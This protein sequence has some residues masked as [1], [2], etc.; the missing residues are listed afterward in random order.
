MRSFNAG[1]V[2]ALAA[3]AAVFAGAAGTQPDASSLL[4]RGPLDALQ[5]K[6]VKLLAFSEGVVIRGNAHINF[7]GVRIEVDRNPAWPARFYE[8][9]IAE[10]KYEVRPRPAP[11]APAA[12]GAPAGGP[13][14]SEAI[15][16]KVTPA[17][18]VG[19]RTWFDGKAEQI[20]DEACIAGEFG[21]IRVDG[22]KEW[23]QGVR[24]AFVHVEGEL[25][26]GPTEARAAF[27]FKNPAWRKIDPEN[28]KNEKM[29]LVGTAWEQDG[30][31]ILEHALGEVLVD[32]K[33]GQWPPKNAFHRYEVTGTV[34]YRQLPSRK[35]ADGGSDWWFLI[36]DPQ[37][38]EIHEVGAEPK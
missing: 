6:R 21:A 7:D 1:V 3:G 26:A 14:L 19:M 30:Q 38:K 33:P 28:C 35:H 11:S 32:D 17:D 4:C 16:R 36:E 34:R 9:V 24:G 18:V 5:G 2:F 15:Y 22:M 31:W 8:R 23:P 13:L 27:V 25:A 29:T 10:G 20:A 12:K 37:V